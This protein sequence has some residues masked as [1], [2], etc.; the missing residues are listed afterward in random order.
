MSTDQELSLVDCRNRGLGD[1]ATVIEAIWGPRCNIH[2]GH[3]FVCNAWLMFDTLSRL[4][5]TST[6]DFYD[7]NPEKLKARLKS[8]SKTCDD[9]T[10]WKQE[11]A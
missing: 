11:L 8:K 2:D 10:A 1:L 7:E 5:D 9:E 6:L 3:C 4:T